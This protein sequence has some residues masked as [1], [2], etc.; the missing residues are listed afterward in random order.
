MKTSEIRAQNPEGKMTMVSGNN[1][2]L[3]DNGVILDSQ[4]SREKTNLWNKLKRMGFEQHYNFNSDEF[5]G[6]VQTDQL[7]ENPYAFSIICSNPKLN[8]IFN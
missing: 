1:N 4:N 7:G 8:G 2:I 5:D 6:L 3:F